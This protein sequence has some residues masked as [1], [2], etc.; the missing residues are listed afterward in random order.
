MK[1]VVPTSRFINEEKLI[2]FVHGL[3]GSAASTWGQMLQI[4]TSDEQLKNY[5]YDCYEYPTRKIRL[6]FTQKM[7]SVQEISD[8]LN[9]FIECHHKLK[10]EII[11]VAHSL[12]GLVARH[13]ILESEKASREHRVKGLILYAS[14]LSGAGM[15]AIASVFNWSHVHLRQL[16]KNT[17]FL[18]GLNSDWGKMRLESKLKVLNV[19]GA[20]DAIVSRDSSLVYIGQTNIR[21]L[22]SRG[23]IDITKP[24]NVSDDRYLSLKDFCLSLSI[25]E[26]SSF[27]ASV[28]TERGDVLFDSYTS[29]AESYYFKRD[30][31]EIILRTVNS[32]HLWIS[33]PPGVGKT[34]ALR[35]LVEIS[36]W[37]FQHI[38]LDSFQGL[39]ALGLMGEVGIILCER[40]G[41]EVSVSC[42]EDLKGVMKL[43][44][45]AFSKLACESDLTIL[46]EEIPLEPGPQYA[47]FMNLAF[48]ISMLA[49]GANT[50]GR[51]L[52]L[53][54][55]VRCP[56]QN[57]RPGSAKLHEKMQFIQFGFWNASEI[58]GLVEL[59]GSHLELPFNS[60]EKDLILSKCSGSPRFLKMFF[61]NSRSEVG[62]RKG[63]HEMLELVGKDLAQ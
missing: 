8:G 11:I 6:P 5:S 52:L 37:E 36:K 34:A 45:L 56:R 23:H 22:V 42:P 15:A 62:A 57:I 31:D 16:T 63:L 39:S 33:G 14:P 43:F 20:V 19:V 12:G 10:K 4:L 53:F 7:A 26:K 38:I 41:V 35:R 44:R 49:E 48:Q 27:L 21:T 46:M 18:N 1:L 47:E 40:A 54:S 13:H 28:A 51:I 17:D 32:S 60:T 59:I 24:D 9:S 58:Q 50:I 3:S 25:P 55:S 2:I 61:R 30:V 29:A